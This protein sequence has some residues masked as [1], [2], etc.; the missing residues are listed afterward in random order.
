MSIAIAESDRIF[1]YKALTRYQ[2]AIDRY[3]ESY[4]GLSG[5]SRWDITRLDEGGVRVEYTHEDFKFVMALVEPEKS[6]RDKTPLHWDLDIGYKDEHI[7]S[8]EF[9]VNLQGANELWGRLQNM[10]KRLRWLHRRA[11]IYMKRHPD[12]VSSGGSV[13]SIESMEYVEYQNSR[14]LATGIFALYLDIP[15]VARA[16]L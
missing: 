8:Q 16:R 7:S 13:K 6:I 5:Y 9:E 2:E 3:V 14:I 10:G 4:K 1:R 15:D 11:R 12:M